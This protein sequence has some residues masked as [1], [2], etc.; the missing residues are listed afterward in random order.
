MKKSVQFFL[1]MSFIIIFQHN[2][3]QG[4]V[5][6]TIRLLLFIIYKRVNSLVDLSLVSK[7]L[8]STINN[9]SNIIN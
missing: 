1:V 2:S 5:C 4:K 7:V 3:P 8:P 6:D 9:Y